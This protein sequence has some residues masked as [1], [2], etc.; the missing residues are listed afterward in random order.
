M[1]QEMVH[2]INHDFSNSPRMII[3]VDI[4]KAYDTLNCHVIHADLKKMGFPNK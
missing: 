1:V 3:E 4:E 2:S